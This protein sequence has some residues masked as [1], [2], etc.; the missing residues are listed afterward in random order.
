MTR[1]LLWS[2]VH[3]DHVSSGVPRFDELRATVDKIRT[4]A[5]SLEVDLVMFLGD[6]CDPDSGP[7]VFRCLE[8]VLDFALRLNDEEKIPSFFLAGNHD[9]LNDGSGCTTLTPLR[10]IAD[11]EECIFLA[12]KPGLYVVPG[13]V[14]IGALP[15]TAPSHGY[16]PPAV[17]ERIAEQYRQRILDL[18]PGDEREP[19]V[20]AGH[21]HIPGVIPGAETTDLP[22]GREVLFPFAQTVQ[23][24]ARFNGHYHRQ[25]AFDPKDGGPPILISGSLARLTHGE[26]DHEPGFI[27][28]DVHNP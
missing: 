1:L 12:E 5:K 27:L 22:R 26:E 11:N 15:F 9:V 21:L 20:Y 2:D 24:H 25:Q 13:V 16:D 10:A 8:V 18:L 4:A 14:A 6:L 3:L 17:V 7:V 23:S 19:L 28:V